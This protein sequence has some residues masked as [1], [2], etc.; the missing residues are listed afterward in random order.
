MP[1]DYSQQSYASKYMPEKSIYQDDTRIFHRP[2]YYYDVVTS[3]E[4]A[5]MHGKKLVLDGRMDSGEPVKLSVECVHSGI[6]SLRMWQGDVRFQ[7]QSPMLVALPQATVAAVLAESDAAYTY[8]FDG[9]RIVL[10]KKPF[11]IRIL[12]RD[13]RCVFE[14][15]TRRIAG[16]YVSYPLGFRKTDSSSEPFVSWEIRND[17]QYFGLGE[18]YNKAEKTSTRATVWASETCGSNTTDMS[19]KS[20]PVLFSTKGCGLM[21]HS[22]YRSKWEIGTFSYISGSC[23]T[24]EPFLDAFLFVGPTL[25]DLLA[26]YTLRTGRPS[27]PP[28]WAMG[29][30]M[31]RCQY[32]K[33]AEADEAIDG[34]RS[35]GIP[36]DV[37]HLDPLWM[38]NHYYWK[39]GVDACDFELNEEHF[40]DQ[41]AMFKEFMA[42]G[43]NTCLWINPYVPEGK[44]IYD[45][46]EAKGYLLKTADGGVARLD[47]GNPV[48]MV[49]FSNPEAKEWWKGYLKELLRRGASVLK[50]DY[51]DRVPEDAVFH[52]GKTGTEM[53]NLYLHL[54]AETAYEAAKEVRGEG[55]VWRRSGYIGSQ[56]YPGT[57]SGDVQVCWEGLKCTMRAGLS[58]GLTGEAFWSHDI[59]GFV[60]KV[61]EP[62]L[63]IRWAQFG[64]LSP[65]SRFHGNGPREPWHYG[66]T[67]V[68]VV[69]HY[70]RLRYALMPYLLAAAH[71]S[72]TSGVPIMRH[73]AL[74]FPN[75]PNVH[76]LDDQYMLG[77][78]I[79]VAPIL[80]E[81]A[82]ERFVYLP[83]GRWTMLEKPGTPLEGGRFVKVAAPLERIPLFVR[84]GAVVPRYAEPPQHLKEPV[85]EQM[86]LD[87]YGGD[88]CRHLTVDEEQRMVEIDY[89]RKGGQ[90]QLE[91]SPASA[92]LTLRFHSAVSI[93]ETTPDAR[94]RKDETGVVEVV[95]PLEK[96][97]MVKLG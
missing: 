11:T 48:G 65:L 87:I 96:G 38:K 95:V 40:P 83:A 41:P 66:D 89:A 93:A 19:Y 31:S 74:E 44:P 27:M 21:L 47:H 32:E 70:A 13:E 58:A 60:G 25:K 86:V 55:I 57:W 6:V 10:E 37:I 94:P 16:K 24:E 82:T 78:D 29:V 49:D 3:L 80:V 81:G 90:G 77:P 63:Y 15:D 88:S 71:E 97:L 52:N 34:L 79:L 46:A 72:C 59:G 61:P 84:D 12:D 33:R 85:P 67:A 69:R 42:K 45:E 1:V 75:E 7:D 64:L 4:G 50:P 22:S 8:T 36:A 14:L 17:E 62:E 9:Y 43:F 28:K 35:E 20:L 56:R 53:H 73:M 5:S 68:A 26:R 18:K 54:Y 76:T 23:M 92:L 2:G 30:W 39:I 91:V 51:G